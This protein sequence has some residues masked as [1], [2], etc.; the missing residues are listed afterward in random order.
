[1]PDAYSAASQTVLSP[2]RAHL[3]IGRSFTTGGGGL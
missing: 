1:V 2:Y 3:L